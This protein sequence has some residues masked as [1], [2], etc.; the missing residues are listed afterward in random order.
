MNRRLD[1]NLRYDGV[2]ANDWSL[3]DADS[4]TPWRD[5]PLRW[6]HDPMQ[7][8]DFCTNGKDPTSALDEDH[9]GS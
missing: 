9:E 8:T 1:D 7:V 3:D 5:K 2:D 4:K 6:F